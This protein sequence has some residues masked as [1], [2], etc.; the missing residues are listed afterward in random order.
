DGAAGAALAAGAAA[1]RGRQRGQGAHPAR[2]GGRARDRRARPRLPHARGRPAD[3]RRHRRHRGRLLPGPGAHRFP[4]RVAR[5]RHAAGG[6]LGPAVSSYRPLVVYR[7]R[8]VGLLV[9]GGGLALVVASMEGAIAWL[10][11][12]AMDGIFIKRDT[13]MLKVIP[14]LLLGAYLV[15]AMARY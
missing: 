4:A 11:K 5:G 10:V 1:L 12:P 6:R 7:R 9:L 15:K 8:Y 14:L 13:V 3:P 2:Q